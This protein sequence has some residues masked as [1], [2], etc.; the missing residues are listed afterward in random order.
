MSVVLYG[1]GRL[2]PL[3]AKEQDPG[4]RGAADDDS[5]NA[6]FRGDGTVLA[7]RVGAHHGERPVM[8]GKGTRSG[9]EQPE[10]HAEGGGSAAQQVIDHKPRGCDPLHLAQ[11]L[12]RLRRIKVVQ[13]QGAERD[14]ER[15]IR[16]G[17][18]ERVRLFRLDT[19]VG[20][21]RCPFAGHLQHPGVM[22]R[23]ADHHRAVTDAG[24]TPLARGTGDSARNVRRAGADIQ[25]ANR[26]GFRTLG[27]GGVREE[28]RQSAEQGACS[29]EKAID[30]RNIAEGRGSV[31]PPKI[32]GIDPF[33]ADDTRRRAKDAAPW[34]VRGNGSRR[35]CRILKGMFHLTALSGYELFR[36]IVYLIGLPIILYLIVRLIRQVRAINVLDNQLR[37]EEERNANNPY[38]QMARMYEAQVLLKEA[39]RGTRGAADPD[40]EEGRR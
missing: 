22:V 21:A 23:R 38:Y 13:C 31:F 1:I 11:D 20:G 5:G 16:I 35:G 3:P 15:A 9:S 24:K 14:I 37:E 27:R 6:R 12:C 39:H 18:R 2:I 32:G 29:T 4:D 28:R 8:P 7:G 19:G 30:A 34:F 26:G 25:Q 17:K 10:T 36:L 40:G 33:G